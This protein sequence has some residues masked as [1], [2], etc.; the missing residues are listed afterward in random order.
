MAKT[1]LAAGLF[2]LAA[3]GK[4]HVD[5]TTNFDEVDCLACKNTSAYIEQEFEMAEEAAPKA[6]K[7]AAKEEPVAPDV[8]NTLGAP[9]PDPDAGQAEGYDPIA[10]TD[11]PKELQSAE[12]PEPAP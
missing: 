11:A 3:C 9:E 10:W 4:E 6:S 5:T 1:H 7:K 2:G 12:D 8:A